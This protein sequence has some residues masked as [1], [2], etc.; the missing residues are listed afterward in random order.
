MTTSTRATGETTSAP[1]TNTDILC[2]RDGSVEGEANLRNLGRL[3]AKAL[4]DKGRSR[5]SF[6]AGVPFPFYNVVEHLV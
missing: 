1:C 6:H 2:L 5:D 3:T 4:S